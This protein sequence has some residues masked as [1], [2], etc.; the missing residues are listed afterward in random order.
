[1][2]VNFAKK[3]VGGFNF[4]FVRGISTQA[5]GAAE[6]GECMETLTRIKDGDFESWTVEWAATASGVAEYATK[7]AAAGDRWS[8][9]GAHLRASNY[10]RM[11]AFYLPH[12]DPRRR[13]FWQRSR[14]HFLEMAKLGAKAVEYADIDFE[15][16]KLP[17][18]SWPPGRKAG[19]P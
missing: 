3:T 1:M 15:G 12:T 2:K 6:F 17:A 5:A 10:F 9:V 11:A 13:E 18:S 8:A 4:E 19:R 7:V 14:D 16:S